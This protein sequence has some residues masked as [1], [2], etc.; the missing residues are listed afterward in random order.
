ML[1]KRTNLK[2]FLW[3]TLF[4]LSLATSGCVSHLDKGWNH[5]GK[6][7]YTQAKT[8]WQLEEKEDL[9]E[10]IEKADAALK[11][12][13]FHQA[14]DQAFTDAQYPEA[15]KNSEEVILLDKWE[16]K[17]WL[18]KSPVLQE[19]ITAAPIR[20]E[21][22]YVII[23]KQLKE[24]ALSAKNAKDYR[25]MI[26]AAEEMVAVKT[27]Q[28][29]KWFDQFPSLQALYAEG[30]NM[31]N[32]GFET[33]LV[34]FLVKAEQANKKKNYQ[35]ALRFA[36]AAIELK[37]EDNARWF[38]QFPNL[39]E[40]INKAYQTIEKT[41][42]DMMT[43]SKNQRRW[44]EIKDEFKNYESFC[45]SYKQTVSNRNKKLYNLA[46]AELEK[47]AKVLAAYDEQV[48]CAKAEFLK[49]NYDATMKC[50]NKAYGYVNANKDVQFNTD[51]LEYVKQAAEQAI[52]IQKA[53]EEERR[54]VA[55]AERKRI[56]E[57]NRRKAEE[58]RIAELERRRVEQEKIDKARRAERI[59]LK[60]LEEERRIEAE[61]KR[62]IAERDRRWRA[63]LKQGAPLQPLVTT[64]LRPSSGV[65]TL[66]KGERQKWQG[67]S[68]LPKP[69]DKSIASE[70]V[71]AL[72]VEIPRTHKITYLRNYHKKDS[73]KKNVLRPPVT[74][75]RT[76]SYYTENFKGGRY[77]TEVKNEKSNDKKYEV[78]A[79]IYKIPVTY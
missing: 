45:S 32:E 68:Q 70:D 28:N 36:T 47:K 63:F 53:I 19:Y 22:S 62:K 12:V 10:P 65:G 24:K 15:I 76:R 11:L 13:Q 34:Q 5:F 69:K 75:G 29:T 71:Y 67:G 31:I 44:V 52:E 55:E 74:S 18:E 4:I 30:E 35:G 66:S 60:K 58:E 39:Q 14:A 64:V 16:N 20:I 40:K 1:K 46:L 73:R 33:L 9:T 38:V 42:Y 37:T 50:V 7:E 59:R 3:S 43:N 49:E 56:E 61:R 77:Y 25:G 23:L 8:E 26:S 54:R 41:Y 21:N 57:E 72:E 27:D 51:D 79:R 78:K 17:D 48:A 6:G 2:F